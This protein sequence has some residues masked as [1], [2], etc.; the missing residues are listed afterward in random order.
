MGK[1]SGLLLKMDANFWVRCYL[2]DFE[3][4][5]FL[6]AETRKYLIERLINCFTS[7]ETTPP[8]PLNGH[9][10]NWVLTL[11][12]TH[13]VLYC[14]R[15]NDNFLFLWQNTTA[16]KPEII[17]TIEVDEQQASL[18]MEELRFS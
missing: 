11:S 9:Q 15:E 14:A 3:K 8:L 7:V 5:L 16:K 4:D 1:N 10:V 17:G 2:T 6:G 18:W 12:E 13:V